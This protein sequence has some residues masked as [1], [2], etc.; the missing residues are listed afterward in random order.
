M[1]GQKMATQ[2]QLGLL[3]L[4][5]EYHLIRWKGEEFGKIAVKQGFATPGDIQKALEIQKKNFKASRLKKLIGDTLVENQVITAR[6]E[7]ARKKNLK[8]IKP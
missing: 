8:K 3:R 6:Q 2:Y 7:T 1:M 4:I 5:Q